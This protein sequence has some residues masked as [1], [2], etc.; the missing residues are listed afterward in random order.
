[1]SYPLSSIDSSKHGNFVHFGRDKMYRKGNK[2]M[3]G[4]LKRRK[5]KSKKKEIKSHCHSLRI[6]TKPFH[7]IDTIYYVYSLI[8]CGGV[9]EATC[10]MSGILQADIRTLN[11]Y[12][13]RYIAL[14]ISLE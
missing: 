10:P 6:S 11:M 13:S 1:M 7:S 12:S 14:N 9:Q 8:N 2:F 5:G 4:S 3:S